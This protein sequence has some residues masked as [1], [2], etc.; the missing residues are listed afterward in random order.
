MEDCPVPCEVVEEF[1]PDW[2]VPPDAGII[3]T[4]MHYRWEEVSAIR[5]IMETTNVP[6]LILSDGLLE[7]RNTFENPT[8]ADGSV[9]QPVIG[10]K[11]AC[12]G[13]GQARTIESWGNPGKCE[14]VGLPRLDVAIESEVLPVQVDG[15]FRLL[16]ATASTPAFTKSQMDSVVG[17][18]R[19]LHRFFKKNSRINDRPVEVFWRLTHDLGSEVGL[20]NDERRS[21][22][23]RPLEQVLETVDAVIT[24]PSTLFLESVIKR[25]PTAILDYSNSPKYYNAAWT[26]GAPTHIPTTL[27]ELAEPPA[28]KMQFQR[29][30]LHDQLECASPAKPRLFALIK[31]MLEHGVAARRGNN[32][33]VLPTRILSD[34]QRGIQIVETEFDRSMLYPDNEIFRQEDIEQLQTELCHAIERLGQ[35]PHDLIRKEKHI[36]K[37]EAHL[38]EVLERLRKSHDR[39]AN[40]LELVQRNQEIISRKN[41]HIDQLT[42]HLNET[43]ERVRLLR[44]QLQE[45]RQYTAERVG[46]L[47][48]ELQQHQQFVRL[49]AANLMKNKLFSDLADSVARAAI[50]LPVKSTDGATESDAVS[51]PGP[52]NHESSASSVKKTEAA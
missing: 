22:K 8:I 51:Q 5:R 1:A 19:D 14:I 50:K 12:S 15:A 46:Q 16:I 32:P 28:A 27:A 35:L 7:Y 42:Q 40:S 3:V 43:L 44:S 18:I 13:R 34:P 48:S 31:T 39:E 4:H 21:G 26:I 10:H 30:T 23:R 11:I 38:A 25:R 36:A 20:A 9:F 49:I 47:S 6:V 45:H 41:G 29:A 52:G 33:L 17:S 2:E 24:T 37:M